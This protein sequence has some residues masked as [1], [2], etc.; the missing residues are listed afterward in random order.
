MKCANCGSK[1]SCGCQKRVAKDGKAC[2]SNCVGKYNT[3][4]L[5]ASKTVK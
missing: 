5:N 4:L 2:C 3:Q 1:L